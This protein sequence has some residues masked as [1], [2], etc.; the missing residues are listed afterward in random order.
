[1]LRKKK[2]ME[3]MLQQADGQLVNL[4]QLVADLEFAQIQATFV[5][6]LKV[7]NEALR[8]LH[9]VLTIDQIE[10][11]LDE[12]REGIDKQREIDE[13]ISG[14]FTHEDE[15]GLESELESMLESFAPKVVEEKE[16][17]SNLP[18]FEPAKVPSPVKEKTE[19]IKEPLKVLAESEV[20][21]NTDDAKATA[22]EEP[23]LVSAENTVDKEANESDNLNTT[24][25]IP[26]LDQQL[27]DVPTHEPRESKAERVTAAQQRVALE[28]T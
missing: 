20:E 2:Y 3:K 10:Q 9:S 5:E 18:T 6:G 8:Q 11:I 16:N 23:E 1:M 4:E 21:T 28:S 19:P 13:L 12:T 14:T 26:E 24:S 17:I 25:P 15:A 27:P 7:G 22:S